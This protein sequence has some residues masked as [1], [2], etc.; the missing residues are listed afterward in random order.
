MSAQ[1]KSAASTGLGPVRGSWLR[2][3]PALLLLFAVGCGAAASFIY[4]FN[5]DDSYLLYVAA[6]VLGG[7]RLYVDLPEVN[8]PLIIWL[9]LPLAWLAQHTGL[10]APLVFRIV[11]L[12]LALLSVCWSG[13]LLRHFLPPGAWWCWLAGAVYAA[14]VL[15]EYDFGEREHIALLCILPYLA[16]AGRRASGQ[17][18]PPLAQL[19]V[20]LFATAG[21]ALKPHFLLAPLLVEAFIATR[22]RRL[23]PGCVAA[24]VLL[25]AYI[26]AIFWLTPDYFAMVRMFASAYWGSTQELWGF[27]RDP[28]LYMTLAL[29][30]PAMLARPRFGH[31]ATVLALACAAFG[32]AA[33]VQNKGW[34]YHWIPALSLAWLLFGLAVANATAT[35]RLGGLPFCAVA[36][37]IVVASLALYGLSTAKQQGY[38][39]NPSPAELGPVIRELGGGPVII[40]SAAFRTSFPLVTEAGIGTSTRFPAMNIVKAMALGGNPEAVRWVRKSFAED[41][42]R[43]PPR[44]LIILTDEQGRPWFDLVGY[45]SPQVPELQDYRQV[46]R[47]PNFIFLAAP[48]K[49]AP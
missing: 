28:S 43:N 36:M 22:S 3:L 42:Y 12:M 14:F 16:E 38:R 25:P 7:A 48:P 33:I 5:H 1:L 45:F 39:S 26:A 32:I 13:R 30:I 27:L 29:A 6:R 15:P 44:L 47:L 34:L 23:G 46:R 31:L 41:F 9:Q 8:P 49:S 20:A 24:A 21:L 35:R 17:A 40:S 11:V 10:A 19:R 18:A 37:G 2:A 4:P